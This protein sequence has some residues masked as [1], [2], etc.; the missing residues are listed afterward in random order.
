[1]AAAPRQPLEADGNAGR[2]V[3]H[4]LGGG[5][6]PLGLFVSTSA[7][8]QLAPLRSSQGG[9]TVTVTPLELSQSIKVWTF[10]VVLDTHSQNL[11]DDLAAI[12]VLAGQRREA[13]PLA[14]EGQMKR[15]AASVLIGAL[16]AAGLGGCGE[17]ALPERQVPRQARHSAVG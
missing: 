13:R 15:T 12:S 5:D 10:K 17:R 4:D 8:A 2:R 16:F 1:M 3:G 14:W 11:S 9:V 6:D 7:F